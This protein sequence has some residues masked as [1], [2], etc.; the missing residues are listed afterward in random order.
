VAQERTDELGRL[1]AAFDVMVSHVRASQERLEERVRAR[2][3]ELQDRNDELEAFAYSISHDLRSPLRA[4]EGF[5]QALIEDYGDRLDE[6]GRHHAERVVKAARR[7][8]ELI[9]DLL[10]YSQLSRAALPLT[11]V[12]L[13]RLVRVALEQLDGDVR[14][15]QARILVDDGLPTVV[16]HG[17]T[18]TQVLVNLLANGVKFVPAERAPEVRVRA[19]ARD[20]RVRLWIEDNGIGI[21][22]EHHERIY[23]VFERLHGASDYPGTGI[24]LA[25]VRKAIERMGGSTGVE[26]ELGRGSRFW[27]DLPSGAT[28]P[29]S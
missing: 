26:S 19:E 10:A 8:D 28:F 16:G 7:M 3:S 22:P 6:T 11:R 24:G 23:R 18:L 2:T 20:G 15:R 21:A 5:S 29:A 1:A 25:I 17:A 9:D 13:S 4:M 14:T 12:D 27:I